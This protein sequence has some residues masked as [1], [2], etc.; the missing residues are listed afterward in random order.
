MPFLLEG[1]A[2]H[3]DLN[4]G[5]GIHPNKAGAGLIAEHMYPKLRLMVDELGG[6]G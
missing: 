6:G 1:V 5:D 4:Q 3:P 2:G